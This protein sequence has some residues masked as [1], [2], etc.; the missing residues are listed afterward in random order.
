MVL[1]TSIILIVLGVLAASSS[2]VAKRPDAKSYI[3]AVVPYQ[4]WL[5]VVACLWGIWIVFNAILHLE[6]IGYVPIWWLTFALS[7]VL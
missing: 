1:I 6:W 4:G 3:D 7:G 5:G 2:I